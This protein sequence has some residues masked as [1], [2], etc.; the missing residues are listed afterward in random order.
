MFYTIEE[1]HRAAGLLHNPFNSIIAPRPIGWV[2]TVDTLGRPNLAPFSYFNAV[3]AD[4]PM[5]MFAPNEKDTAGT[6]KDSLRNVAETGEFVVN[7]V[8]WR[9]RHE[10]N[11]TS[12]VLERGQSEFELAGLTPVAS[13][14]VK[15]PRIG[16]SPASLECKVWEIIA[17]PPGSG[18]RRYHLVLGRVVAVHIADDCIR[19]GKVDTVKL[20]A[21]A[22]LGGFEYTSVDRVEI[23][24]R[25]AG[26]AA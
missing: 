11:L 12:A 4:P 26:G 1:G 3:A 16:E 5:V 13:Q 14:L 24:P 6:Q 20:S 19:D 23:I 18:D 22:R 21:M 10:M 15:P 9:L 2:S 8:P 25:P 17:L 7:V